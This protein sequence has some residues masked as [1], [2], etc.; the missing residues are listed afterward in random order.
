M[1]FGVKF[2]LPSPPFR[3]SDLQTWHVKPVR[4]VSSIGSFIL[5]TKKNQVDG[6]ITSGFFPR[7]QLR[8]TSGVFLSKYE[9]QYI[10]VNN[11]L[12][13]LTSG[14]SSG[15]LLWIA[16]WYR[17]YLP[18]RVEFYIYTSI[19]YV[20]YG[21]WD[22]VSWSTCFVLLGHGI[23]K[24]FPCEFRDGKCLWSYSG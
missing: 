22:L 3:E 8:F 13:C 18:E 23:I 1:L 12:S 20:G 15:F 11:L 16:R 24:W 7:K 5:P 19:K 21:T 4:S 9:V 14:L 6:L 2:R 17:T 10:F